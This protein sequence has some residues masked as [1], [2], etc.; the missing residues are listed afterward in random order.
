VS[1]HT[2]HSSRP[3]SRPFLLTLIILAAVVS[4]AMAAPASDKV[5]AMASPR[6]PEPPTITAVLPVRS[7]FTRQTFLLEC[8]D[9]AGPDFP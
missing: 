8:Y 7:I 2:I 6:P 1:L 4:S 5:C 9:R 3:H